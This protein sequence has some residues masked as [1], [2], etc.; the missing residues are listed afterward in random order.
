MVAPRHKKRNT[1]YISRA[2]TGQS[3]QFSHP[4]IRSERGE[5]IRKPPRGPDALTAIALRH[6]GMRVRVAHGSGG[7]EARVRRSPA[8]HLKDTDL[9]PASDLTP[10]LHPSAWERAAA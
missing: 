7:S 3:M 9:P 1:L 10:P 2:E 4:T 6:I 5:M 8:P